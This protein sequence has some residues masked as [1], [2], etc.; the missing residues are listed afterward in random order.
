MHKTSSIHMTL[1]A[2]ACIGLT[3][4]GCAGIGR[5]V[6]RIGSGIHEQTVEYDRRLSNMLESETAQMERERKPKIPPAY[7]YRTLGEADCYTKPVAGAELRLIGKQVPEPMFN[8]LNSPIPM[9][10]PE[11]VHIELADSQ[12]TAAPPVSIPAPEPVHTIPVEPLAPQNE[13]QPLMPL[14]P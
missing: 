14:I 8:D 9:E 5:G 6:Q 3:L 1:L 10:K 12:Q 4:A 2:T 11:A 13:P 7:C